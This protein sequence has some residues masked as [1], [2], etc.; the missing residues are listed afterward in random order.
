MSRKVCVQFAV[1]NMMIMKNT[2]NQLGFG[3]DEVSEDQLEIRRS[4]NNIIING[5]GISYDSA[6]ENE[7]N[8]IKQAYTVNFYK[9]QAVREGMSLVEEK[10]SNGEIVL[11]LRHG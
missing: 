11:R 8:G 4:Y 9:D 5:E 1:R 10:A 2:L 3:F 6:N 7:I